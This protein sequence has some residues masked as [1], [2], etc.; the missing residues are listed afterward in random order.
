[1]SVNDSKNIE[2]RKK[3]LVIDNYPRRFPTDRIARIETIVNNCI[4]G[5]E[6]ETVHYTQFNNELPNDV[7]GVIISG[8][9]LNVSSFYF[10]NKLKRRFK[11]QLEF[12]RQNQIPILAICFGFHLVAYAYG[13]Q[14]CR[15]QLSGLGGKIIFI[16][17]NETDNL[18]PH[19]NIPVNIHHRDFVSPNDCEIQKNFEIRATSRTLGYKMIQYMKHIDKSIFSLQFHP[20]THNAD[21]FHPSLF[22]KRI[23]SRTMMIGRE[24]IENFIWFCY[25]KKSRSE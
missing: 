15:M 6:L 14:I 24:I 3:I 12:I 5:L 22:D 20:E 21:Y 1:M 17:L 9:N 19:A 10:N 25:H 23:T 18:I 13:A 4:A 7:I 2:S 16:L 11:Y 8:S